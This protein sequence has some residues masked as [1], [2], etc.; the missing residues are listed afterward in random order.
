MEQ[1]AALGQS[2][3]L[4][5]QPT[6]HPPHGHVMKS[7]FINGRRAGRR[8]ITRDRAFRA[9]RPTVGLPIVLDVGGGKI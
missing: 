6:Q 7:P 4:A 8:L 3:Q 9:D 5:A 2:R 1:L